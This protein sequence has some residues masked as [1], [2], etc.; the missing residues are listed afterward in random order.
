MELNH[1]QVLK[2]RLYLSPDDDGGLVLRAT[3]ED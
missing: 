2:D 3:S 1:D